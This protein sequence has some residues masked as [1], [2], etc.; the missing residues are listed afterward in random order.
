MHNSTSYFAKVDRALRRSMGVLL[1]FEADN[2]R[3]T[4]RAIHQFTKSCTTEGMAMS[5]R[6]G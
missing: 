4:E 5:E 3:A 1:F 6:L 2:H